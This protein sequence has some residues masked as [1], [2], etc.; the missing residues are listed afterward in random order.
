MGN[1]RFCNDW[2]GETFKYSVRHSAHIECIARSGR[3]EAILRKM[4]SW[5]LSQLPYLKLKKLDLLKLVKDLIKE[6][7]K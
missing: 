2:N 3:A 6:K 4:T 1:C 7:E 5:Q